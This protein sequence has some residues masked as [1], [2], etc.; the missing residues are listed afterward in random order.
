MIV[1]EV[2]DRLNEVRYQDSSFAA[3]NLQIPG[4]KR[5]HTR[6]FKCEMWFQQQLL[7]R[8]Q[9]GELVII[10]VGKRTQLKPRYPQT[11]SP[12][13]SLYISINNKLRGLDKRSKYFSLGDY[14]V[15][16]HN[17]CS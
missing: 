10:P 6:S 9:M 2:T 4:E 12:D 1:V 11:N 14:F 3:V 7:S 5:S 15:Y 16:S 17:L 8:S 13:W